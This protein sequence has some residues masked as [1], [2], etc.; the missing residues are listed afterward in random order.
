MSAR[1]SLFGASMMFISRVWMWKRLNPPDRSEKRGAINLLS[2]QGA[3]V[4]RVVVG[5]E[6]LIHAP[7]SPVERMRGREVMDDFQIIKVHSVE[8]GGDH[9]GPVGFNLRQ[10]GFCPGR[11]RQRRGFQFASTSQI[12]TF[13]STSSDAAN[14]NCLNAS[15]ITV[16]KRMEYP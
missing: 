11:E 10:Q 6:S 9:N 16:I 13:Y 2:R 12:L 7:Q 8:D 1:E 14:L 15:I 5:W 4:V 3:V